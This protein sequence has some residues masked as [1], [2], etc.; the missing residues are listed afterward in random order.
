MRCSQFGEFHHLLQELHLDDGRFQWYFRLSRTQFED[1][2]SC[3][4]ATIR[5]QDTNYRRSIP[6]A[7]RLFI[8]LRYLATGDSYRTIADS[9]RVGVSTVSI[10]V[11]RVVTAIWDSLRQS[12]MAVLTTEDWRSIAQEFYLRWQFPLCCGGE[13][14]KYVQI[15]APP[16]SG[17]LFHNYKGNFSIVLLV[18]VDTRYQ[19]RVIDV[20]GYGR[21][22]NGGIL[23]NSS[24]GQ[25]LRDGTLHLPPDQL[26]PGAADRGS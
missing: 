19:F 23:A 15:Q 21:I 7:E 13:D 11:P 14:G 8:C 1:L 3:I 18:V 5:L 4:G 24:F 22:S 12:F 20:G 25:A 9:F 6:A 2:L 17:S 16:N 26:L 10:I